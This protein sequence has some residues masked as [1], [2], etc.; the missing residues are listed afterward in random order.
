MKQINDE[1]GYGLLRSVGF[2]ELEIDRLSQLRRDY[3]ISIPLDYARLQFV[4][5]LV[6]TG[7][8]T[9]HEVSQEE[10]SKQDPVPLDLPRQSFVWRSVRTLM[11]H[12]NL[13]SER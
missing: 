6:T 13:R 1:E 12:T 9:D 5:W 10:P 7:R 2:T 8:L 4:R 3:R 11:T